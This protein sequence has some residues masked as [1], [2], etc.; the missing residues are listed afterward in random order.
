MLTLQK[1]IFIT[2]VLFILSSL[3]AVFLYNEHALAIILS[4][5]GSI[6]G[7]TTY[8]IGR[9]NMSRLIRKQKSLQDALNL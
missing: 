3:L 7:F 8:V 1:I 2:G 6:F 9:F 5:I 4:L